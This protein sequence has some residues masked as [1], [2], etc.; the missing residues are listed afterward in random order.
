[1][2]AFPLCLCSLLHIYHYLRVT[3]QEDAGLVL[4]P[5]LLADAL[6]VFPPLIHA[7]V[8]RDLDLCECVAKCHTQEVLGSKS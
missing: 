7:V 2:R 8:P 5:G 3:E 6:E 4:C 1:M